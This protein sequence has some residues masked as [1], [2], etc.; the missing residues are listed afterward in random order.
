MS[1]HRFTEPSLEAVFA[2]HIREINQLEMMHIAEL[3]EL[4][5]LKPE[6]LP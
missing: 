6:C 3:N 1:L 4:V 2:H 5:P